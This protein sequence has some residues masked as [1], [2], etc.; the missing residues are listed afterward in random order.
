MAVGKRAE[1]GTDFAAVDVTPHW[2]GDST[3]SHHEHD[4]DYGGARRRQ[5]RFHERERP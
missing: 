2:F 1:A 3:G 5:R 4:D